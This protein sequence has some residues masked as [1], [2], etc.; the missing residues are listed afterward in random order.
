MSAES[1]VAMKRAR[2]G[3]YDIHFVDQGSGFPVLLIHGLAGDHNAW[4]AQIPEWSRRMRV[5]A[6]DT[7]GAGMST[8]IDESLTLEDLARDFLM[9]M[10]ELAIEKCHVVGRSM[11]GSISQ[12]MYLFAPQRIQSLAWIASCAKFDPLGERRLTC[13]REILELANSWATWGRHAVTD[14]VSP[15]FYNEQPER[16]AQIEKL[17]AGETRLQACYVQ[18]NK[19]VLTHDALARLHEIACP[20]LILSGGRD[21][22]CGPVATRWMVERVGHARWIEFENASH[23][24]LMEE[25]ERFMQIMSEWFTEHTPRRQ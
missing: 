17:I 19:A 9:L 6:P 5:I 24:F 10:D 25:P 2:I 14:F 16:V 18:Q 12:L 11:G 22:L 8:Q 20:V 7:R 1:T 13:H 15:R 23:F 4:N 21:P 3:R